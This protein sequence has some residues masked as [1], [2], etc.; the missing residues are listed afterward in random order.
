MVVVHECVS[1]AIRKAK[2]SGMSIV[3]GSGY[4]SATGALG[5]WARQ[6][7]EQNLIGIVMSQCPEYVAPHGS[8]E[9]IFGTNPIA[10]GVPTKPRCQVLDMATSASA[11]YAL[12]TAA[13]EGKSIPNDIAVDS[14]GN[15]TTDPNEALKGALLVFDRSFK[16]SHIALMVELLAGYYHIIITYSFYVPTYTIIVK[17]N[18]LTHFIIMY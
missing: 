3:G 2:T 11:Y 6:I 9:P 4:S 5:F 14:R 13:A 18:V 17:D 10:I 1:T 8:Y 15:V 12:V 16:G 7:A